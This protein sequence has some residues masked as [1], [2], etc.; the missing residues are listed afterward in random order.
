MKE[1]S[2]QPEELPCLSQYSS[3]AFAVNKQMS[4]CTQLQIFI[5]Q[6]HF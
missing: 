4:T 1:I 2:Q 3:L 6:S 5:L